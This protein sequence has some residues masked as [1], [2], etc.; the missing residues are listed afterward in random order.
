MMTL[1]KINNLLSSERSKNP[2]FISV[3]D[4][5]S[6]MREYDNNLEVVMDKYKKYFISLLRK[7]SQAYSIYSIKFDYERKALIIDFISDFE[8][9]E[10]ERVSYTNINGNICISNSGSE[11]RYEFT[12]LLGDKIIELYNILIEICH[13]QKKIYNIKSINSNFTVRIIEPEICIFEDDF[14]LISR[15]DEYRCTC[16]S[17]SVL[18]KISCDAEELLKKVFIRISDCPE[19]TREALFEFR[20]KQ[21]DEEEILDMKK[22]KDEE[23]LAKKQKRLG[24]I[25][26]V[27][28]TCK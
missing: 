10:K 1:E 23:K 28:G 5:S 17:V 19:W 7:K 14:Q 9:D 15:H 24:I 27:F 4:V 20:K 21:L 11:Y 22:K 2:D 18:S 26:K 6:L 16:S 25:R 12:Q 3:Y 8:C 13:D